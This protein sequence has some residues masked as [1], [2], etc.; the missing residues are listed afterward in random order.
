MPP[1]P[2]PSPPPV[3]YQCQRC[4]NCCRWPGLVHLTDS[5]ITAIS[6]HLNLTEWDFIQL[7]TRLRPD[8]RGLALNETPTGA[9][10]FLNGR[11]CSIQPAKPAQCKGFPNTWNFPGWRNLC[12]AIPAIPPGD[13][14]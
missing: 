8:R 10:A 12:E 3:W 9:C 14:I 11:D 7:H 1:D 5:D 6:A 4:A 13:G 2:A